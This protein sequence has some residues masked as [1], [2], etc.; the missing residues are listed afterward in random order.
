M[1]V[2]LEQVEKLRERS[3]ASYTDCK[4]ALDRSGGDLL[5]ALLDL[6]RQGKSSTGKASGFYTTQPGASNPP[7]G[8]G[9]GNGCLVT[10]PPAAGKSA[11]SWEKVL[12][13][14]WEAFL[15]IFRHASANRLEI[16]RKGV[17]FSSVPVAVLILLA[18]AAFWITL[19]LVA[20]GLF[21]GCRYR[22]S[23]PDVNWEP[24]NDMLDSVSDG[25]ADLLDRIKAAE[26]KKRTGKK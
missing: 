25:V 11:P 20:V 12:R 9:N 15:N 22:F 5:E 17:L 4:E 7:P 16:W 21:L 19:P 3:G 6:E 8:N 24:A 10:A 13:S 23:G 1:S 26:A 14:F 2:T 18:V